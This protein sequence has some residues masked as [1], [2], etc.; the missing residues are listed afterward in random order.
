MEPKEFVN[1]FAK[2]VFGTT[3]DEAKEKNIC[4]MCKA[5][6][7]PADFKDDL[8]RAEYKISGICQKCQD[9]LFG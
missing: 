6:C 1:N 2:K 8:S 7:G 3:L 4:V 9:E 5:P